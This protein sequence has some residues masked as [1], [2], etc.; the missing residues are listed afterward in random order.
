[1]SRV[2]VANNAS[3]EEEHQ[4]ELKQRD[5]NQQL[6]F[7]HINEQIVKNAKVVEENE[8]LESELQQRAESAAPS[9]AL[10]DAGNASAGISEEQHRD[11]TEKHDEL[12]KK[13]QDLSQKVKYLEKKNTSVMQ[14]N[15]DMKESVRAWQQYADR[16]KV[17][18]RPKATTAADGT[19]SR[20]LAV[21]HN[22]EA[23]P[24]M[25]SSPGSVSATRTSLQRTDR[26]R[27]SPAP[28]GPLAG[29]A[30]EVSREDEDLSPS[31][32]V[33]PR[34]PSTASSHE[35][36]GAASNL[37]S[38][39]NRLEK[40]RQYHVETNAV[41]TSSQ[42]TVDEVTDQLVR[43]TQYADDE[44]EDDLPQ[45]VSERSLKR[46]RGQRSRMEVYSGRSSDGTP[47][48]PHR[49]KDE[50]MSS[51]PPL[52]HIL[53]RTETIDLDETVP[54]GADVAGAL[55][56]KP[57]WHSHATGT[58]R[59]QRSGSAPFTQTA[60]RV[61]LKTAHMAREQM[62]NIQAKLQTAADE[63][64]ALSEPT[65]PLLQDQHILQPI[66]V[67]VV[68]QTPER[69]SNKRMKQA[70]N[71]LIEH[72]ILAESGEAPPPVDGDELRLPPSAARARLQRMRAVKE[73]KA[74][75]SQLQQTS[76][77]GSPLVKQEPMQ[78]R[79]KSASRAA[80]P[81]P[82][83][84][85]QSR[86]VQG[87]PNQ[88]DEIVSDG[89]PVWSMRAPDKR[90]APRKE[91]PSPSEAHS[92]LRDKPLQELRTSDFKPN[93]VYNNG[94]TY[95]FSEAVRKR[96]DRLCLPGC[97]NEQCCGSHFRRLA[98]ALAP[99]LSAEEEALLEDYLGDAYNTVM[100][101]QMSSD[102]RAEL[103]LQARTKKI[104]KDS[105]KHRETYERR[106]T[107][108]GFWRVDFPSTQS[109]EMDRGRAKEL[110]VK[111]VQER[112][113]EAHKKGGRWMFRDE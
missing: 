93:P 83:P 68:T 37:P 20:L 98:E 4:N 86:V 8:R 19:P 108:P 17:H 85:P 10:D 14:K 112:W 57:S 107:P 13:Y 45:V 65:G 26:G 72:D 60:R 89:R 64:R 62:S 95:A 28:V 87:R 106:R 36:Q 113:L 96:G 6:L 41:P 99:L 32:S 82:G 76:T 2:I 21:P 15:R 69:S 109:Q 11:L 111:A 75:T 84:S 12:S 77:T 70:A 110:E 54:R 73:P 9:T 58:I 67:N 18:Q 38:L 34:G 43:R 91:N 52:A 92:R 44:N 81:S 63:M 59:H 51:P 104:A 46:K 7:N 31:A 47:A 94:Y 5:E 101:T 1:M 23:P 27:S 53:T 49:V 97:T 100:S 55:Q 25:P 80:E 74:P 35:H 22:D 50:P 24:H 33:T 66:D 16:M 42:T 39:S 103:I 88:P 79:S 61:D 3:G 90:A 29:G 56:R 78:S 102:E 71:M 48:K 40:A 30:E 105:G